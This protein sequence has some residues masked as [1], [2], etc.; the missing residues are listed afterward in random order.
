MPRCR[1][2]YRSR[3][4][5]LLRLTRCRRIHTT[6]IRADA[7]LPRA[8]KIADDAA[9]LLQSSTSRS[10][11]SRSPTF[12]LAAAA[13]LRRGVDDALDGANEELAARGVVDGGGESAVE[14]RCAA[15]SARRVCSTRACKRSSPTARATG[16]SSGGRARR[17]RRATRS[18]SSRCTSA[19][20]SS[21][22][23]T[24]YSTPAG[25]A[26]C[27]RPGG[28]G[29]G[30]RRGGG[31][32]PPL[33][34]RRRAVDRHYGR[35]LRLRG[36]RREELVQR[37]PRLRARARRRRAAAA[38][39]SHLV[40][41]ARARRAARRAAARAARRVQPSRRDEIKRSGAD[42]WL[43]PRIFLPADAARSG[44]DV[45]DASDS[46]D[47]EAAPEPKRRKK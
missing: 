2:R 4:A 23:T 14:T 15:C 28:R 47:S 38:R 13:G 16:S 25:A 18:R 44:A 12:P 10:A 6:R 27:A 21:R 32:A 31:R 7:L 3:L 20:S 29:G 8:A 11:A 46:D 39:L 24:G 1:R 17:W 5:Q 26:R 9:G 33:P 37:P 35:P 36:R 42:R 41:R 45:G 22:S 43:F 34:A 30:G 19:A 40:A